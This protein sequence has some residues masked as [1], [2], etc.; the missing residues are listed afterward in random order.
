MSWQSFCLCR[1]LHI[2]KNELQTN[3]ILEANSMNPDQ[4]S[5]REQSDLVHIVCNIGLQSTSADNICHELQ[6][7]F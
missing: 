6:E 5:P 7:K 3:F 4:T 2:L 1:L